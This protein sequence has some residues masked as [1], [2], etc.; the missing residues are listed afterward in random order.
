MIATHRPHFRPHQPSG[1]GMAVAGISA[2]LLMLVCCAG[3]VLLT[4]GV[5]GALGA[6]LSSPWV[7]ATAVILLL[8]A[9]AAVVRRRRA[10]RA[11]CC[12]PTVNPADRIRP[13]HPTGKED[14]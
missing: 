3:P 13:H 2:A 14:P 9:V 11:T 7:I 12:P 5:L 1:S 8:A 10:D 4:A 6:W